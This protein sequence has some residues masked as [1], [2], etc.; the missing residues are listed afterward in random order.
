MNVSWAK[1]YGDGRPVCPHCKRDLEDDH[2]E[3]VKAEEEF[4]AG[5][6]ARDKAM[7]ALRDEMLADS[8]VAHLVCTQTIIFFGQPGMSHYSIDQ[9]LTKQFPAVVT[10]SE[11]GQGFCYVPRYLVDS[12]LDFLKSYCTKCKE[13]MDTTHWA[14]KW[15]AFTQ[16]A[17]DQP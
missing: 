2:P 14:V 6:V 16:G 13:T 17:A 3:V 1:R 9:R 15:D 5:S 8:E 7:R 11:S 4:T 12:V 10:D